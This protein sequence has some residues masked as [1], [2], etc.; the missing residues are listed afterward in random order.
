MRITSDRKEGSKAWMEDQWAVPFEDGITKC[1]N[2][3][4]REGVIVWWV[5]S[6]ADTLCPR[7]ATDILRS[8]SAHLDK[9]KEKLGFQPAVLVVGM[10]DT[11]YETIPMLFS[12]MQV[13]Y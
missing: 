10:P 12:Q 9:M 6:H 11:Q 13:F 4:R 8:I 1:M 7:N 3:V 5:G 2:Y